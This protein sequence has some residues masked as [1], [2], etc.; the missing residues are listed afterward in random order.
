VPSPGDLLTRAAWRNLTQPWR[1]LRNL[2]TP[3]MTMR[4][5]GQAEAQNRVSPPQPA[6]RTR[7]NAAVSGHRVV[8]GV[9][10]DLDS[11]RAMR[12]LE[13]GS[14]VND[15]ILAIEG[16][17]LREYLQD[18][19]E[20]PDDSLTAM[21]PISVRSEADRTSGGNQVSAMVVPLHTDVSDPQIRLSRVRASTKVAKE[22]SNAVEARV[23]TDLSQYIPAATAALAGRMAASMA[24]ANENVPPPYNTVVTNVPGAQE[25][26]YMAGAKMVASYGFG[27]VH[28]NMGLMN[29]VSSYCGQL[30]VTATADR[31]MMPDP[32]FYAEC[33]QRAHDDLR[34]RLR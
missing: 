20:L 25:A 16:G 31:E 9:S 17:A 27:M 1:M 8:D 4:L 32:A 6:P 2:P 12:S 14:T 15:V 34:S 29:V 10:F 18:K 3:D 7:F 5:R 22:M 21:C 24:I 13:P 26:L 30:A 28:D 11:I 23:L 33:I 19:G